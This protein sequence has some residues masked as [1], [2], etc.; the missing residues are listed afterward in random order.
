M[1]TGSHTLPPPPVTEHVGA[2]LLEAA[3]PDEEALLPH[4]LYVAVDPQDEVQC[5]YD[6]P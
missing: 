4:L 5:V 1:D 3:P 2:A 6:P